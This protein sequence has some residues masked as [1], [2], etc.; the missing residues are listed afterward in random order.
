MGLHRFANMSS[1]RLCI[2][3][4]C[5][6]GVA[7]ATV[8]VPWTAGFDDASARTKTVTTGDTLHFMWTGSHNVF[9]MASETAFNDCD[10]TGATDKGS[11]SPVAVPLSGAGP[12]YFACQV[13]AHCTNG[14]KLAVTNGVTTAPT[15]AAPTAASPT[16]PTSSTASGTVE[17]SSAA[18]VTSSIVTLGAA[19][20]VV[21]ALLA[22]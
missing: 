17:F 16:P 8:H 10:F 11:T 14:Q 9:Q 15:T 22:C 2:T 7:T 18:T 13:G 21:L 3:L 19:V 4:L 12:W 5:A 20:S 6:L 1:A